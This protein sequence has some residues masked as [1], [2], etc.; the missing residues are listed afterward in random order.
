MLRPNLDHEVIVGRF[1]SQEL[2]RG[3]K[4]IILT[5]VFVI[6][7]GDADARED[8]R[9]GRQFFA[10]ASPYWLKYVDTIALVRYREYRPLLTASNAA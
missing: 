3:G 5:G 7:D 10:L 1:A 4:S 2:I 9:R 8:Q 6:V